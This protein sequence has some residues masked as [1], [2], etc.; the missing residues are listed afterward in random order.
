METIKYG[1][2]W[3]KDQLKRQDDAKFLSTYL[4][5]KNKKT[6]VNSESFVL[7]INAEWGFGKTYFI[8]NWADDLVR[9]NHPV[10]YFDAWENDFSKEPLLALI[11]IINSQITPFF[12]QKIDKI[13]SKKI[14]GI[15][16]KWYNNSKKIIYPSSSI[17]IDLI[18]KKLVGVSLDELDELL[19]KKENETLIS[20]DVENTLTKIISN[21]TN[22]MMESHNTTK[23]AISDFKKN[24]RELISLVYTSESISLPIFIFIDELDRCRPNYAIEILENIKHLFGVSGVFFVVSTASEQLSHSIKAIYGQNFD[25]PNYLKRFF[26]QT[27]TMQDPDRYSFSSYIFCQ[28]NLVDRDNLFSP[29]EESHCLT[30]NTIVECFAMVSSLFNCGLR[31]MIQYCIII[32][33]I[34]LTYNEEK[35]HIILLIFLIIL[36][37][38]NN[39]LYV[40]IFNNGNIN[41][42]K[43]DLNYKEKIKK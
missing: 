19:E 7:N 34:T 3:G 42:S 38:K 23:D 9:K 40:E 8:K 20:D 27:Y 14:N 32:D 4:I 17:L 16:D 29:L 5:E 24:I 43:L 33:S 15:L 21:T 36:K 10:V 41:T 35:I 30:K 13:N 6:S 2:N 18:T 25:S 37:D 12:N 11:S 39:L 1:D 22:K 28:Y 26:D 31:D